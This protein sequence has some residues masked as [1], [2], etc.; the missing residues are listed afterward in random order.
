MHV[1]GFWHEH[2]R[3]DRDEYIK[4]NWYNIEA[5]L[6]YNFDKYSLDKIQHLG[7][8]YDYSSIL[9]YGQWAFSKGFEPTI[10]PLKTGV[11]IGQRVALSAVDIIKINKLYN[12]YEY[13]PTNSNN[14]NNTLNFG[15]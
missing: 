6:E 3:A 13:L 8:M 11:R 5:G 1:C 15:K 2:S 10:I 7:E 9:H 4:I 12:C 14:Y